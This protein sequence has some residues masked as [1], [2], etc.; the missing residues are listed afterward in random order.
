MDASVQTELAIDKAKGRKD[1]TGQ[2][3]VIKTKPL[4]DAI[5]DL[6]AL[7]GKKQNANDKFNAAVKAVA[8]KSG[9]L[10]SVVRKLVNARAGDKWEEESRKVVQL[11]IVFEEVGAISGGSE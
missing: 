6:I 4:K 5:D 2:E 11:G 1:S 7:H 8:E 3:D 10:S 9:L